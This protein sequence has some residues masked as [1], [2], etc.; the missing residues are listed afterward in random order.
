M[1]LELQQRLTCLRLNTR[2]EIINIAI[3]YGE[4]DNYSKSEDFYIEIATN[5]KHKLFTTEQILFLLELDGIK[6]ISCTPDVRNNFSDT[7]SHDIEIIDELVVIC[8]EF[9]HKLNNDEF[10]S[11]YKNNKWKLDWINEEYVNIDEVLKLV[12]NQARYNNI[13]FIKTFII[14]PKNPGF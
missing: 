11:E 2:L 14:V 4:D 9:N 5:I 13:N 12:N 1:T 10:L 6:I 7:T 8:E 3:E